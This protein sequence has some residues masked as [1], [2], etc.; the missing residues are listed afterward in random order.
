MLKSFS[1]QN[2]R[3]FARQQTIECRPLTL[4]FGRNSSGKSAL[5]RFLPLLVES[6]LIDEP[7]WLGGK[8]G[9]KA[10]WRDLVCKATQDDSLYFTLDWNDEAVIQ[11][12]WDVTGDFEDRW[13]E[14]EIPKLIHQDGANQIVDQFGGDAEFEGFIPV[15]KYLQYSKAVAALKLQLAQLCAQVQWIS[16][17]RTQPERFITLD[18]GVLGTLEHDG[19]NAAGHLIAA[20][21]RSEAD[22]L[23]E[24]VQRFFIA[25]GETLLFNNIASQLWRVMLAP[26]GAKDLPVDLCDTGEGYAQVLPVLV[27]LARA[28]TGGPRL[29]CLEQPELHLHTHAQAELAKVLVETAN[30]PAQPQLLVET[31]SEVLL[32]SVQLAIAEGRIK[33]EMV[34]V[35]WVEAMA[36]GTSDARLVDFDV[37]G[38]PSNTLLMNAFDEAVRLGQSLMTRQMA[39]FRTHNPESGDM[40]IGDQT[41]QG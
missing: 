3:A 21:A 36:D 5:V 7:I 2:Y 22:P 24:I 11:A 29:L 23:L 8:V 1:V 35:Y 20:R 31:H 12:Q 27:A 34:R 19:S 25:S 26:T 4:F 39:G 18:K 13:R 14:A 41:R 38:R 6:H 30:D 40:P 37:W 32:T 28:R 9:R 17:I 10:A 16:G 15:S 33:P